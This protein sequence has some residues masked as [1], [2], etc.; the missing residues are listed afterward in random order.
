ME[1]TEHQ[2]SILYNQCVVLWESVR[3]I[4]SVRLFAFKVIMSFVKKYPELEPELSALVQPQYLSPLS[5]GIRRSI[6]K[7]LQ[8]WE[9]SFLNLERS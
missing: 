1:R 2:D 5:P 8:T 9:N 7:T 4:P 6:Q 3:L